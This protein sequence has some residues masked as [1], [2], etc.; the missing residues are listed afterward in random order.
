MV[1]LNDKPG[2]VYHFHLS[3]QFI[4]LCY[5]SITGL[6][7]RHQSQAQVRAIVTI[8]FHIWDQRQLWGSHLLQNYSQNNDK[9]VGHHSTRP[10]PVIVACW[11]SPDQKLWLNLLCG[12]LRD[13]ILRCKIFEILWSHHYFIFFSMLIKVKGLDIHCQ[14]YDTI[15]TQYYSI[16]LMNS[17]CRLACDCL[18]SPQSLSVERISVTWLVGPRHQPRSDWLITRSPP[19]PSCQANS[20]TQAKYYFH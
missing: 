3:S 1:S 7:S 9:M 13:L 12:E 5:V 6:Q 11:R 19:A 17:C 14:G 20:Y 10:N 18:V 8:V 4:M 2:P 16:L 15:Q